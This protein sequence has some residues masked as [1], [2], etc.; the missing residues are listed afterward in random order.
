MLNL[1][2]RK[3]IV[4]ELNDSKI[5]NKIQRE[6]NQKKERHTK[7]F[8]VLVISK[9]DNKIFVCPLRRPTRCVR[10]LLRNVRY[11][12]QS[13]QPY[14]TLRNRSLT[15]LMLDSTIPNSSKT[16]TVFIYFVRHGIFCSSQSDIG[17]IKP[18]EKTN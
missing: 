1:F 2:S 18:D 17:A 6:E 7:K 5:V 13:L 10:L 3:K 16:Y 15:H 4:Q 9:G 8:L 12:L 14:P 11:S